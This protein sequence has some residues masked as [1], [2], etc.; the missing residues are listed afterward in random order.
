MKNDNITDNNRFDHFSDFHAGRFL[1]EELDYSG[2][3]TEWLAAQT[4]MTV[5]ELESL[6][7]QPNMDAMLFVRVGH[8]MRPHFLDRVHEQIF[9][10]PRDEAL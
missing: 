3:D 8:P 9:G 6:F 10:P 4:G 5:E 7:E 1:R 2:H